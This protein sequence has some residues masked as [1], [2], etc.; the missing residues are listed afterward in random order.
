MPLWP[1]SSLIAG[2]ERVADRVLR[3]GVR[4]GDADAVDFTVEGR[5]EAR[6]LAYTNT[7]EDYFSIFKRSMKEHCDEQHLQRYL[8]E[9]DFRYSNRAALEVDDF[10]R[11]IRAL[12]G[13]TGKR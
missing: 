7:L 8:A 5:L 4:F 3:Q 10:D 1:T 6:P 13:V 11:T 2:D 12:A 9:F